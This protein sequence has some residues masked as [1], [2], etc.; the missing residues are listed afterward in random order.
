MGK[1]KTRTP[2]TRFFK[3]PDIETRWF[4]DMR[5]H[6]EARN[7]LGKLVN[8]GA[9]IKSLG[10]FFNS[11]NGFVDPE[12]TAAKKVYEDPC[13]F[14]L[15]ELQSIARHIVTAVSMICSI[16]GNPPDAPSPADYLIKRYGGSH[17]RED[18][19]RVY[20]AHRFEALPEALLCFAQSLEEWWHSKY[21]PRVRG[22]ISRDYLKAHFYVYAKLV[23]KLTLAE[24]AA[25]LEAARIALASKAGTA[26]DKVEDANPES[27][28]AIIGRFRRA[29]KERYAGMEKS[30]TAW[31]K[32]KREVNLET[33]YIDA[34]GYTG[35]PPLPPAIKEVFKPLDPKRV[36]TKRKKRGNK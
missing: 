29:N 1:T 36:A 26:N 4:E 30:V 25:L 10:F 5:E 23:A 33:P 24:V 11:C 21:H 9:D 16:N 14:T 2:T 20:F 13:H 6:E 12:S 31:L 15:E 18:V 22:S 28:K 17:L 3:D 27:L 32:L 8:S 19:K 35:I 34:A 7:A